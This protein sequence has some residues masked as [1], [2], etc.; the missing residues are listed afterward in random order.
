VSFCSIWTWNRIPRVFFPP[1]KDVC[2]TFDSSSRWTPC[3]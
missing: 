1:Q 3:Q 2:S